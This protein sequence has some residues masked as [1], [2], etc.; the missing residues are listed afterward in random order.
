MK[1]TIRVLLAILIMSLASYSLAHSGRTDTYGG[2]K[3][4]QKSINKGL[5]SG[6]HYHNGL[7]IEQS[8]QVDVD[9]IQ[10]DSKEEIKI[11]KSKIQKNIS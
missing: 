8:T 1:N 9:L 10:N 11:R 6:Y 5:C 2:H 3:C 7:K 4:S